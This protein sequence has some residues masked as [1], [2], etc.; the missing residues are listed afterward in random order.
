[1]KLI[2]WNDLDTV[3]MFNL[4][5]RK[6]FSGEKLTIARV[7]LG[8]GGEVPGHSHPHE[9]MTIVLKGKIVFT[10][11]KEARTAVAGDVIH[12][13]PGAYHAV[14]ALEDS[15]VIDVFSPVRDDWM[16]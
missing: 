1:M 7:D 13:P 8:Q 4:I 6:A 15:I 2:N 16:T 12:T 3:P 5:S 10:G 9:Q 11:E 14:A